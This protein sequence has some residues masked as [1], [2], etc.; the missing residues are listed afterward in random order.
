ML[1]ICTKQIIPAVIKFETKVANSINAMVTAVPDVDVSVQTELLTETA[2]LLSAAR[3]SMSSLSDAVEEGSRLL[4]T[5]A[6]AAA[7]QYHD[8]V[9]KYMED[10]R[11]S[12]DNLEQLVGKED[13]PMP[14]YG[15]L[16]FEV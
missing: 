4:Q 16:L 8:E 11:T 7:H 10:L 2:D 1:N 15:D 9:M 12:V 6:K 5:D 3:T 13:W 14:S